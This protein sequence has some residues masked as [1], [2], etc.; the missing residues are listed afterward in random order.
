MKIKEEKLEKFEREFDELVH[1]D[2]MNIN[3]LEN[4]MLDNI[5]EYKKELIKHTEELLGCH[6]DEKRLISKKNKN[7]ER[8]D[9]N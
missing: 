3:T 2:N 1:Q 7:G 6:I 5:D 4:L 8:M 9:I